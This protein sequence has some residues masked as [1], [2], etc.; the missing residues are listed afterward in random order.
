VFLTNLLVGYVNEFYNAN[1]VFPVIPTSKRSNKYVIYNKDAFLR[2]TGTDPQGKSNAIRRPG[3][4]STEVLFDLSNNP[5]YCEQLAKN[6]PLPYAEIAYSDA[7]IQPQV[8]AVM[9]LTEMVTLDN[10]VQVAN[11]SHKRGNYAAAN[12][13]QLVNGTTSWGT[14][15]A[16]ASVPISGD[17]INA[18]K[19]VIA[20]AI[21][22]ATTMLL[23]YASAITLSQNAQYIDK[24]KYTSRE[25][26]TKGG[27][28]PVIEGLDVIEARAQ[29]AN[30]TEGGGIAITTGY[31]WV[32]DQ[33]TPQDCCLV[34]YKPAMVGGLYSI[35]YGLTFDAPDDVTNTQGFSVLQWYEPWADVQRIEVRTTRDWRFVITDGSTN[36]DNAAGYSTGAYLISGTT[37]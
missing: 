17:L 31:V 33:A 6:Y 32:D 35:A 26:L 18:K 27:L 3:A 29:K 11:K 10:E 5:F 8:A 15:S 21:K 23:N 12:K 1:D 30:S 37:L 14:G 25:G 7:P 24:I 13:V 19:A 36:G 9:A 20:G 4:K 34:Y 28:A 16:A 2:S 22:P